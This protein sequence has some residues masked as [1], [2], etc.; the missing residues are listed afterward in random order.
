MNSVTTFQTQSYSVKDE[1]Q[2]LGHF[3][4][5]KLYSVVLCGLF[6][7]P[8]CSDLVAK[9]QHHKDIL[10]IAIDDLNDWPSSFGGYKG[11]AK[12]PNIDRL[13]QKSLKFSNSYTAGTL[14]C[15]SRNA[16]FWGMRQTTTGVYG[17]GANSNLSEALKKHLPFTTYFQKF[18]YE[19]KGA[20]KLYHGQP[21]WHQL[22]TDQ[23]FKPGVSQRLDQ[24]YVTKKGGSSNWGVTD[25]TLEELFDGRNASYI[26]DELKKVHSK[27]QLL[28]YGI[29]MPHV[30]RYLPQEYFD[31]YP[32]DEIILPEIGEAANAE[33]PESA[34]KYRTT[35]FQQ[36]IKS[37]GLWKE[38][39]Q[40]YLASM[41]FADDCLG[42]VLDALEE[43][44]K[45]NDTI[46]IM[47]SDHGFHLG[48]KGH[49]KKTTLW[50]EVTRNLL[51]IYVPGLTT[52]NSSCERTVDSIDLYPTL[53]DLANI[54]LLDNLE[55]FSLKPL[56]E[57]GQASWE[58]PAI[59]IA[60]YGDCNIRTERWAYIHYGN[61]EEELYDMKRDE[62]QWHNLANQPE[63]DEII[64]K[65]R[66]HI[67]QHTA[68]YIG[69]GRNQKSK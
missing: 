42:R 48:E 17:N 59:T 37:K 10:F 40:A 23:K 57:N 29:F 25:L 26:I 20:G 39:V 18:G 19:V 15:P 27:P 30:P 69:S 56:L 24:K 5:M 12:T 35:V 4:M 9:E 1:I 46:I 63:Y 22:F 43:T 33:L 11:K 62:M 6:T 7:L 2:P 36:K 32:L 67:P 44:G 38:G 8:I 66:T 31:L 54:P 45:I 64:K 21:K 28:L 34:R 55:G 60:N 13:V 3:F 41:S 68:N 58:H 53:C 49:W 51:S 14:C 47:W 52:P 50:Q 65:L 16:M 61:G